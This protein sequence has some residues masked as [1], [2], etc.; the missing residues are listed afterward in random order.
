MEPKIESAK[1]F[2]QYRG[3]QAPPNKVSRSLQGTSYTGRGLGFDAR[4][5]RLVEQVGNPRTQNS[6]AVLERPV[7]GHLSGIVREHFDWDSIGKQAYSLYASL[8]AGN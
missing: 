3:K 2:G 1:G 7:A 6:F 5:N 8:L 4:T